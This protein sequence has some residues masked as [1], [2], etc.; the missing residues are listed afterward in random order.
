M[1]NNNNNN[2]DDILFKNRNRAY[3]AYD[4]RKKYNK[5]LLKSLFF[6]LIFASLASNLLFF[7]KNE[8]IKQKAKITK[9]K[10]EKKLVKKTPPP[11]P[12]TKEI[13]QQIKEDVILQTVTQ[14]VVE[15]IEVVKPS[16]GDG[17]GNG[18]GSG[19]GKGSGS[20]GPCIYPDD[21]DG[22]GL[23]C[24]D[25]CPKNAGLASNN[26]CPPMNLDDFNADKIYMPGELKNIVNVRGGSCDKNAINPKQY[27]C[28]KAE[29]K[30][31]LLDLYSDGIN[32]KD[33]V[34]AE[35]ESMGITEEAHNNSSTRVKRTVD[36]TLII[37]KD[38]SVNITSVSGQSEK[39]KNITKQIFLELN[40]KNN[41]FLVP[42]IYQKQGSDAH[43]ARM[44]YNHTIE[45]SYEE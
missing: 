25:A 9:V 43:P 17:T 30:N 5:N 40:K 32:Y 26:G 27:Q 1:K 39:L 22:D 7:V 2:L 15:N 6:A 11:P 33:N 12:P 4:I 37:E 3:G 19:E 24:A 38:G 23:T 21:L 42:G 28:F 41:K 18:T 35:L 45:Y 20:G 34:L 14:K 44:K 16:S 29:F 13:I 31:L 10:L 8:P 36:I